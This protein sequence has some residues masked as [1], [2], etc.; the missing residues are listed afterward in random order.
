M[1]FVCDRCQTKYSIADEKVRGKV[2]KVRCKTCQN[3]ITVREAGVRPSVAG[4]APVR[5]PSSANL[6]PLVGPEDE[7]EKCKEEIQALTKR[8][9]GKVNDMAEKK[10]NEIL[11]I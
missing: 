10:S 8:F 7:N 6:A 1:K 2:L 9:E 3:V 11:E 4:L 5:H